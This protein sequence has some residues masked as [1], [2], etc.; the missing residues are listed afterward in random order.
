ML[1]ISEVFL[2]VYKDTILLY[3]YNGEIEE[4]LDCIDTDKYKKLQ[5]KDRLNFWI[6][7]NP[8][9]EITSTLILEE[10]IRQHN[11]NKNIIEYLKLGII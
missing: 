5:H 11:I 1:E 3:N 10:Y 8:I 9:K 6:I 7:N 2:P 4:S